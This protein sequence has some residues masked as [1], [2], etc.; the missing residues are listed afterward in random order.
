M[1][2]RF[3][4]SS[5]A[6]PPHRM[7]EASAAEHRLIFKGAPEVA[8]EETSE[9]KPEGKEKREKKE[10]GEPQNDVAKKLGK[11]TGQTKADVQK[12][13]PPESEDNGNGK[14]HS[15]GGPN[16]VQLPSIGKAV[17]NTRNALLTALGIAL[18]PLGIAGLATVGTARYLASK[19]TDKPLSIGQAAQD[20]FIKAPK[21]GLASLGN[22]LLYPFHLTG[23][24]GLNTL[25]FT[26]DR[27][28]RAVDF[29]LL[30][31]YREITHKLVKPN[32]AE[33]ELAE[34][35]AKGV[36]PLTIPLLLGKKIVWDIP[37]TAVKWYGKTWFK[38]PYLML[39]AHIFGPEIIRNV[40][41]GGIVSG[42][43]DFFTLV[44]DALKVYVSTG[45]P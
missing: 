4:P 28:Y 16:Y 7:P 45:K 39:F 24:A 31:P 12:V 6:T 15:N 38:H 44:K 8:P 10:G 37:A 35:K 30:E 13:I 19:R 22:M 42:T 40:S 43:G 2:F 36:N 25:K 23:A 1:I 17:T 27:L 33:S 5:A 34:G 3:T 9:N 21:A 32:G 20:T 29:T 11:E 41:V 18:P 14:E 26:S